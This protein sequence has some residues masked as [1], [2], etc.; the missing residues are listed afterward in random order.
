[1]LR[2][3]PNSMYFNA[4]DATVQ[5]GGYNS[6]HETRKFGLPALFFPNMKTGMDDQLA[7]C[8]VAEKEGWGLV[9]AERNQA[10]IQEGVKLL[11]TI[12]GCPKEDGTRNGATEL[13]VSLTGHE[14]LHFDEGWMLPNAVFTWIEQNITSEA[15]IL[16][17]GSGNGSQRLAK[18]Y[19]LWSV[20][21]DESWI[22]TTAST[23]IQ[24]AIVENP[25]SKENGEQGWYDAKAMERLPADVALI[26]V[27]GPPG[28]IGR[29][30]LLHVLDRL[31]TFEYL[32]IDDTDRPAERHLSNT[33]AKRLNLKQ[34]QYTTQ[35][36]KANG[37]VRR[38]DI[39]RR[40]G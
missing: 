22:G 36:V 20:E 8:K 5:A 15:R 3:Y 21:H 23:Y 4:F 26:I 19:R 13:Y 16:E 34:Q 14:P 9:V 37:D 25:V 40:E 6:Y 33:I 2:D 12:Q 1:M 31:P 30:G 7:R 11:F 28:T 39:L 18:Q 29:S 35:Q 17:F 27:D 10:S 24:A 38:F 32:L